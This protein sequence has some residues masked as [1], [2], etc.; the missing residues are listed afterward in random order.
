MPEA[1]LGRHC[2][3]CGKPGGTAMSQLKAWCDRMGV[4]LEGKSQR[5]FHPGRCVTNARLACEKAE[6]AAG[7]IQKPARYR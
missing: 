5:Y 7:I 3:W 1:W 2:G 6:R 4:K